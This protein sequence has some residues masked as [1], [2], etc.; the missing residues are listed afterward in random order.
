M[1]VSAEMSPF[2]NVFYFPKN[3]DVRICPKNGMSALKWAIIEAEKEKSHSYKSYDEFGDTI[4]NYT[5]RYR[6]VQMYANSFDLPFRKNSIRVCIRRDP[7]SRFVSACN[8]LEQSTSGKKET[9]GNHLVIE[10]D[11]PISDLIRMIREEMVK[12]PH[13]YTQSWYMGH[14]DDYDMIWELEQLPKAL[15]WLR[16]HCGIKKDISTFHVNGTSNPTYRVKDL[17]E[18]DIAEIKDLYEKD[19]RNG[20]GE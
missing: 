9:R 1:T 7:V 16:R 12:D 3:I 2:D 10:K 6:Q 15:A 19:Y 14:P 11:T 4:S 8:Y 18:Q 5:W 17:T 20:W 13:F